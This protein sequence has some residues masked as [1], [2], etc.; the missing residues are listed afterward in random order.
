MLIPVNDAVKSDASQD[1]PKSSIDFGKHWSA[2]FRNDPK[3]LSFVLSRYKFSAQMGSKNRRVIELGCSDGIGATILAEYAEDYTGVDFD[4]QAIETAKTNL[5]SDHYQFIYADFMGKKFGEFDTA[6]S[7]DV[8]EHVFSETVDQ[9]YETI[10]MNLNPNG[11][12]IIGTPNITSASYASLPSQTGHVNLYSQER[13]VNELGQYF[14]QVLPFGMNDEILHTG[15]GPM[16]HYL[17]CLACHPKE[18][19]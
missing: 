5:P 8:I 2:N 1:A 19:R 14:H 6:V 7:L 18:K 12:C 4:L 13:L 11:M 17:I 10:L 16:C 3:R 15:Y 9:Y